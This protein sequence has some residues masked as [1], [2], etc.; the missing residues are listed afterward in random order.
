MP[1]PSLCLSAVR[2]P[3]PA[4]ASAWAPAII[5]LLACAALLAHG[6]VAQLDNYH[7]FAD[8][9]TLLGIAHG[10]DVLSNIG[11]AL[12]GAAGLL[13]LALQ[14][15]R[16]GR[17]GYLIFFGALLLTA[18]GSSWYHL[19]PD[20]ARLLADR[21]PIAL[22]CAGLVAAVCGQTIIRGIGA[23]RVLTALLACAAFASVAWWRYTDL[24]G[25]GDLGPYLLLQG[26]TLLLIPLLQWQARRP[27]RERLAF[28]GSIAL[29][30]LAKAC[31]LADHTLFA[32]LGFISGHT[33]KHLL[34]TAAAL[35]IVYALACGQVRCHERG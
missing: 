35:A 27:P 25:G 8:Q 13:M 31:E 14:P 23:E 32:A 7:A 24:Q 17:S 6:P 19:A 22:A 28:A 4:Q 12:A 11:F 5:A 30:V 26:L 20:N 33:I 10:A 29:Y 1:A 15:V 9:R 16:A 34:A 3:G 2:T 21:M 18:C